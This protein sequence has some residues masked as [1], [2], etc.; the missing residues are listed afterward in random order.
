[1]PLNFDI[2]SWACRQTREVVD[3]AIESL[4]A[5]HVLGVVLNGVEGLARRYSKYNEY[6][7]YSTRGSDHTGK[8]AL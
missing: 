2:R 4:G 7:R 5:E 1:M 8:K 6:Y 3:A